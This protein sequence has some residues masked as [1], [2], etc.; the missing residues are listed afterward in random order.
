MEMVIK[1][2]SVWW[3]CTKIFSYIYIFNLILLILLLELIFIENNY[4]SGEHKLNRV[5]QVNSDYYLI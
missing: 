3:S 5:L 1:L 4:M 2:I